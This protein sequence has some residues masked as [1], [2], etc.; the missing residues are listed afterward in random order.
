MYRQTGLIRLQAI[1]SSDTIQYDNTVKGKEV[2]S[3]TNIIQDLW[4]IMGE[5]SQKNPRKNGGRKPY[6]NTRIV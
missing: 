4:W 1:N 2:L 3:L 5:K 6:Q